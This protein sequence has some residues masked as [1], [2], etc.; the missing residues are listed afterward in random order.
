MT[1]SGH[2]GAFITKVKKGS[3]ADRVGHLK[4]GMYTIPPIGCTVCSIYMSEGVSEPAPSM[5]LD[6]V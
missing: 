3:I 6:S 2:R 4:A 1:D 5:P